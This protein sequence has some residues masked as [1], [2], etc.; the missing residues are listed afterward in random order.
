VGEDE[1]RMT[2]RIPV[3]IIG[4]GP[5]GLSVGAHLR[6]LG[7][8]VF[9]KPMQTWRESMPPGMLLRSAWD[10]TSLSAP[11]GRGSI[12]EW[13]RAN[14]EP[15]VEPIPLE[16]F[17]RYSEWFREKFVGELEAGDIVQVE[18][19]DDGRFR[20]LTTRGEAFEADRLVLAVGVLP[21]QHVP[22]ELRG[23][24]GQGVD[25]ATLSPDLATL[26]DREV[27]V[28]GG[29]QS[30][31]ETAGLAVQ[32]GARVELITRSDV[33]WFADREPHK[34]RSKLGERLYRLA[35][36]AVGYGPPPLNR[37]VLHP[38][39]YAKL[40]A[41]LRRRLTRRLLRPGGSP[42]LRDLVDGQVTMRVGNRVREVDRTNGRLQLHLEDGTTT[43]ADNVLVATGYR[44]S[45]DAMPF[46]APGLRARIA[47]KDDWPVLDRHFRSVSEPRIFM[48][49]YAAEGRFGPISRYVLGTE[50]TANRVREGVAA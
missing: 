26:R 47:T 19:T 39:L 34:P 12:G 31:L 32:A 11:G 30:A 18:A 9:G 4:A 21:F 7:G 16:T 8:R 46:L 41:S 33:R 20:L 3:A 13:A 27:A 2:D 29:G 45:L 38:D 24:L 37:L 43:H 35:Y 28:V 10:E 6:E 1:T 15:R 40:P 50:F 44:F 25:L 22:K 17:L 49:G 5:F 48:V 23:L 14:G 36:P 42:W